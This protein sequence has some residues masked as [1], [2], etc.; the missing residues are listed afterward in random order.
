M[1][2]IGLWSVP[3]AASLPGCVGGVGRRSS[4]DSLGGTGTPGAT[5]SFWRPWT[6]GTG[7]F[8]HPVSH[9]TLNSRRRRQES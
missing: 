5:L 2:G 6:M 7:L 8:R 4:G 3:G 1:G 9:A